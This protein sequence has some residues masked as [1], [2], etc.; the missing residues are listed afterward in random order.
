MYGGREGGRIKEDQ[1]RTKGGRT[2]EGPRGLRESQGRA[3]R[4]ILEEEGR[5]RAQGGEG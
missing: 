1:G 4:T 2:E 3:V 5:G